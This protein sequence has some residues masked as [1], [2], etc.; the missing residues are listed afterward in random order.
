M[1]TVTKTRADLANAVYRNVGL[2]RRD[3][4]DLVEDVL[5]AMTEAIISGE[6]VR[7]SGFGV[8]EVRHKRQRI[9]RNPRTGAEAEITARRVLVFRPSNML[10]NRV[11]TGG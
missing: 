3:C 5:K 9:G 4:A 1:K 2:S 6:S 10:K 8:F 7:L 11:R